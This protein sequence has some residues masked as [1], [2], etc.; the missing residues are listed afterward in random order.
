MLNGFVRSFKR[1]TGNAKNEETKNRKE[2]ALQ[3]VMLVGTS[4]LIQD[5]MHHYYR[6]Q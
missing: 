1:K 6:Q 3:Q 5:I 4:F 2:T